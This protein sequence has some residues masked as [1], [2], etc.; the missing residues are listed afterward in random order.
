MEGGRAE[1]ILCLGIRS[2]SIELR[3][4]KSKGIHII[5]LPDLGNV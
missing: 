2:G 3:I 4:E 5:E 1:G